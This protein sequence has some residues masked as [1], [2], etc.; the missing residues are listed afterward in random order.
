M[1]DVVYNEMALHGELCT[2]RPMLSMIWWEIES[3][4][5]TVGNGIRKLGRHGREM[6]MRR[7]GDSHLVNVEFKDG[8]LGW[9]KSMLRD[10]TGLVTYE[11]SDVAGYSAAAVVD[12][13]RVASSTIELPRCAAV[14]SLKSAQ[15][16]VAPLY[17]ACIVG[18]RKRSSNNYCNNV[19]RVAGRCLP[20]HDPQE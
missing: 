11:I 7:N 14:E 13:R 2:K 16:P 5:L 1:R 8:L 15:V 9:K 12:E 19:G 18:G 4:H 3:F 17:C 10:P 6:I 20:Q